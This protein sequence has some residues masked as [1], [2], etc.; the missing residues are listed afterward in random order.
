MGEGI[1]SEQY[2]GSAENGYAGK[3][4]DR[5][6]LA[7]RGVTNDEHFEK[8]IIRKALRRRG[9]HGSRKTNQATLQDRRLDCCFLYR[10]DRSW[11]F[12]SRKD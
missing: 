9:C 5:T 10:L 4:A 3:F 6:Y 12:A 2:N 1:A 8:V 11:L 7:Y